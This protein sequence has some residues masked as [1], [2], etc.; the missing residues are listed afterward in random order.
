M[1]TT[2]A[3]AHDS[4]ATQPAPEYAAAVDDSDS[5]CR[6]TRPLSIN[7]APILKSVAGKLTEAEI[8]EWMDGLHRANEGRGFNLELTHKGDLVIS[9]MVNRDGYAAESAMFGWLFIWNEAAGPGLGTGPSP[10][11]GTGLGAGPS[12]GL[13]AGPTP[14][15][16]TGL[17]AGPSPGPGGFVGGANAN[18]R[19][20]DGARIRPD[21]LWL[22]P[23][24]VAALP[25]VSAGGAIT[26][27]PAFVVE[28]MSATDTLPPLQR[29]MAQY[30]AN[31]AQLAWL[32]DPYRRRVHI[33][34]P[35][36]PAEILDNPETISGD[37]VLPGFTFA[38]RRRIFDLHAP[39]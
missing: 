6:L 25:P 28:I 35:D 4:A 3:I 12:P 27:C 16:G 29:K 34:R 24:Q 31:G 5:E 37:P 9:P 18:L 20:P 7:I 8:D 13:G 33:Y 2:P 39:A 17:G 15:P 26:I 38:I 22:S 11:T 23:E 19:L 10:G 32:I 21:A 14:G 30:L 1:T 36:H